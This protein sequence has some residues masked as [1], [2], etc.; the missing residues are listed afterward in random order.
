MKILF[1]IFFYFSLDLDA[2]I[3]DPPS[4][5][6]DESVPTNIHD[7]NNKNNNNQSLFYGESYYHGSNLDSYSGDG[8]DYQ[9]SKNYVEPSAEE[10]EK[11]RETRKESQKMNP[12]YLKDS[13][14][15]KLPLTVDIKMHLES[16]FILFFF[17][18]NS[19]RKYLRLFQLLMIILNQY[20][21]KEQF[22]LIYN[23][24][25]LINYIVNQK[26]MKKIDV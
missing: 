26:L 9:K 2:W 16:N 12:F 23:Y 13:S 18:F 24:H 1:Y 8:T 20:H 17:F 14:K 10:L 3:N 6:E 21:L 15:A 5:S 25:F 7:N 4:E 11:Q 22:L 19:R